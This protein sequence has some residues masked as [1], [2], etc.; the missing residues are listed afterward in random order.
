MSPAAAHKTTEASAG[1]VVQ[2]QVVK[3][4]TTSAYPGATL[5]SVITNILLVLVPP[6]FKWLVTLPL[7]DA[8]AIRS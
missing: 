4:Q 6:V 7:G 5:T 3:L 8:A 2:W 1:A